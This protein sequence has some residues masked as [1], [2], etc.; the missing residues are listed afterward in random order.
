MHVICCNT[1]IY[2]ARAHYGTIIIHSLQ[3]ISLPMIKKVGEL[4][5]SSYEARCMQRLF[6]FYLSIHIHKLLTDS[7][8]FEAVAR[9]FASTNTRRINYFAIAL[10]CR[11]FLSFSCLSLRTYKM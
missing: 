11:L 1:E 6:L 2:I 5:S 7:L 8:D 4:R 10:T 9:G 3:Y